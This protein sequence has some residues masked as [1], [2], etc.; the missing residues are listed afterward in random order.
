MA[1]YEASKSEIKE[2]IKMFQE[3]GHKHGS[4]YLEKLSEG[5]FTNIELWVKTGVIAPKTI[6][7]FERV[8][9]QIGSRLKR[10]TWGW[11][12]KAVTNISKMIMIRHYSRN[13]MGEILEGKTLDQRLLRHS[14]PVG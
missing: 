5:L 12:D 10:I 6:S 7:L 2:L 1:K 4:S 9:R 14:N 3:K 8:F 13:K 11:Y